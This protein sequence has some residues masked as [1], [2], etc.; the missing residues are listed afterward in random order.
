ML[1]MPTLPALVVGAHHNGLQA[2]MPGPLA[3]STDYGVCLLFPCV[4]SAVLPF[5]HWHMGT[6]L[7]D[8]LQD[9]SHGIIR[10]IGAQ[11]KSFVRIDKQ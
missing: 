7:S 9:S 4:P 2:N 5:R 3:Q 1:L 11:H 6:I 10:C 8:L